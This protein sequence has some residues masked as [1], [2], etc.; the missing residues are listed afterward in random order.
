MIVLLAF[1]VTGCANALNAT[2]AKKHANSANEAAKVADW[3]T[4]RK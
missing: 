2:N 4:A 3:A 1:V